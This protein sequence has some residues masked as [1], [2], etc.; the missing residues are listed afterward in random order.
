MS[1]NASLHPLI[2]RAA[3]LPKGIR[4]DCP[5]VSLGV[6]PW[7]WARDIT[8]TGPHPRPR[9]ATMEA[10]IV[11]ATESILACR[12]PGIWARDR[13]TVRAK[14]VGRDIMAGF[15]NIVGGELTGYRVARGEP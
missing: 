1:R 9:G 6:R 4:V 11:V 5:R 12:S 14:H 8:A 10:M 15:K 2:A 13:S 3:A 7:Y